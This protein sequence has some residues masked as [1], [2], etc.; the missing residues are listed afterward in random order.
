MK[1][2]VEREIRRYQ[3][4]LLLAGR[5]MM[6]F[7]VWEIVKTVAF[8]I[9][10][11]LGYFRSVEDGFSRETVLLAFAVVLLLL[12]AIVA[13]DA[14]I[15]YYI[16]KSC[17]REA[18]EEKKGTFY[19][20]LVCLLMLVSILAIVLY[21]FALVTQQFG[22]LLQFIASVLVEVASLSICFGVIYSAIR[23]RLMRRRKKRT[24]VE[25][26]G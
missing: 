23:L 15:R 3:D 1:M 24:E 16:A 14:V 10:R 25:Y 11:F 26:A 8:G 13:F 2:D 5:G 20:V 19:L 9:V 4:R 22:D 21:V 18:L 7:C 6:L 17:R 12:V